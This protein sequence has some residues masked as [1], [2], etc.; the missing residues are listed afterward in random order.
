[1]TLQC[2]QCTDVTIIDFS[3]VTPQRRKLTHCQQSIGLGTSRFR[4]DSLEFFLTTFVV[5]WVADS[6]GHLH[7]VHRSER[8]LLRQVC[9]LVGSVGISIFLVYNV[10]NNWRKSNLIRQLMQAL[11]QDQLRC[12]FEPR[13]CEPQDHAMQASRHAELYEYVT[14][15]YLHEVCDEFVIIQ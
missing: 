5:L 6:R 4:F 15:V 1:M 7:V 14:S 12:A 10:V 2:L 11:A 3:S 9:L 8:S 13:R